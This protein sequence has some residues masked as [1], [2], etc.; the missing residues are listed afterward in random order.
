ETRQEQRRDE[1]RTEDRFQSVNHEV[2]RKGERRKQQRPKTFQ[3]QFHPDQQGHQSHPQSEREQFGTRW[4]TPIGQQSQ[5]E[6]RIQDAA[7]ACMPGDGPMGN[8]PPEKAQAKIQ[9]GVD[10]PT[11]AVSY[12]IASR[13]VS[14]SGSQSVKA[15]RKRGMFPEGFHTV[16]VSV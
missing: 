15:L 9:H 12:A 10:I 11:S 2:E 8:A 1:Q 5:S 4:N 14:A 16:S 3:R 6:L 13:Q 7:I